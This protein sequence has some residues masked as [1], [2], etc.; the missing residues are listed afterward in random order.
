MITI[1]FVL[2]KQNV[3]SLYYIF[4]A[5]GVNARNACLT[6][7]VVG[8]D[9]GR[10]VIRTDLFDAASRSESELEAVLFLLP[11]LPLMWQNS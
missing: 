9:S 3:C 2:A 7:L 6:W 8:F 11:I 1:F 4:L 10:A 5:V